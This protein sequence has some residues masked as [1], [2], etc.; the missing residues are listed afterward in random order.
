V[1]GTKIKKY[2]LLLGLILGI[3]TFVFG[4]EPP[5]E[6]WVARYNG[7]GNGNDD[8][9]AM[10]VDNS[11]NV[12]I[13]GYSYGS[14]TLSDYATVKYSPDGNQLWAARYNGPGNNVDHADAL[15]VDNF[16]NV[17]VTGY[18]YGSGTRDDYATI[19]Y[20]PDGNELWVARYNG[21]GNDYDKAYALAVDNSGNVYVTGESRVNSTNYD[22]ATIKYSPD[23]N[24]LW[25]TR[26]NG[27]GDGSDY[28]RALAVNSSGNVYVTGYSYGSGTY[29]DYATIK[30]SPDG[31][32]LW[33]AR[34]N[35]LENKNDA[36]RALAVDSFGNVYVT[37]SGYNSGTLDDYATV[38]YSPDGN[39][40]WVTHYN[41]PGNNL[42]SAYALAVDD[43]G[44]VYVT[45]SSHGSGTYEDYATI[46]YSPDGNQLWVA[47]YNGTS[48]NYV[49]NARALTIDISGNVY[50]TGRSAG[51]D[52]DYA[53]IKYS[54]SGNQLWAVR[55]NGPSNSYDDAYALAVDNSGNVYVA[56]YSYGSGTSADYAAI[57]Y[58][59]HDYCSGTLVG[60]LNNDCKVDFRDFAMLTS[61]WLECNYALEEDCW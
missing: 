19:K 56:G 29:N 38:K 15:A 12:Y 11:G 60:D 41:G 48:E 53:T 50:V 14:D 43:S 27:P 59:Q 2:T 33:V 22:Y 51:V 49:D 8:A 57:K 6:Q 45:G 26:Y 31:N 18:S 4:E 23:G 20:S 34:Y 17:Y 46:K 9:Y 39:Q 24:Q 7:P 37:G 47:R 28:A 40:L 35:G 54:P 32:Q 3:C 58:T 25:V 1:E 42:D 36:A 61:H 52:S 13:A 10:A 44:N 21:P 16:G 30:Y 5:V 55:Y